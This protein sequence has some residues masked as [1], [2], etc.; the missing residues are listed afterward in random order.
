VG[1][2]PTI[3]AFERAKTVHARPCLRP[4]GHCDRQYFL[5]LQLV[6]FLYL[7]ASI[8]LVT[9]LKISLMYLILSSSKRRD[10]K[11]LTYAVVFP[12]LIICISS[13]GNFKFSL[14]ATNV[15]SLRQKPKM[16]CENFL[17]RSLS[18]HST[19]LSVCC[20]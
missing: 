6:T 20:C 2:E 1:F 10:L 9:G 4:R 14:P 17:P 16:S 7:Y 5:L 11:R 19:S 13:V 8:S 3:P 12:P 18:S 15:R